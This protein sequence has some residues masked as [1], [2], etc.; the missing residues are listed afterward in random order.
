[1]IYELKS[2]LEKAKRIVNEINI[3][4]GQR[5]KAGPSEKAFYDGT[6]NSLID[7][8]KIINNSIPV[9]LASEEIKKLPEI[10]PETAKKAPD[11]VL[12]VPAYTGPITISSEDKIK[13]LKDLRIEEQALKTLKSKLKESRTILEE[14]TEK[15]VV[16]QKI[17]PFVVYSSRLF[18]DISLKLAPKAKGLRESLRKAGMPYLVNSY[19][20]LIIF[21]ALLSLAGGIVGAFVFTFLFSKGSLILAL[22]KNL[23]I[24]LIFPLVVTGLVY[25]YPSSQA[26]SIK[27]KIANEL[28]FAI[29]HMSA[30]AGSGVEPTK[31]FNIIAKGKEYPAIAKEARKI[32]NQ[33]NFYGYDF[34]TSLR[35]TAKTTPS[36]K[37]QELLNGMATIIVSGGNLRSYLDKN[38]SDTL[39]DYK[40]S[41]KRYVEVSSTYADIY[42]GLLIA[43]PL[44]FMLMLA[45]MSA[46]KI[47][48]MQPM[49]MAVVGMVA[50]VILNIGF[51]I[52]LQVSQPEA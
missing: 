29:M 46:M 21:S 39:L 36:V 44:I 34:V 8:L 23:G 14:E 35:E 51:L 18:P 17:N 52:F 3:F 43:A 37:L 6:I 9:I 49:T 31:V 1:M 20:A 4:S 33:I 15:A 41:R 28:P 5:E 13:F 19:I 42:T 27:S 7:A 26:A 50:L 25:V 11:R 22:L 16:S 48:S 45:L 32:I 40:L 2:N 47:G 12:R 10:T 24:S 38:A 30:I